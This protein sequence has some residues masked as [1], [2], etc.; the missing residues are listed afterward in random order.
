VQRFRD[1]LD[2]P[3][4]PFLIGGLGCF[5]ERPWDQWRA[6]VDSAHRAL[7]NVLPRAAFISADGLAHKGD[8]VHFNS[9]AARELGRRYASAYEQMSDGIAPP[10]AARPACALVETAR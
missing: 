9:V 5:A 3:D 2:D 7:P 10:P 1:E 8:T 4:L 6:M